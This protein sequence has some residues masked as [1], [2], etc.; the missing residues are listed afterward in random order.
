MPIA[1]PAPPA[2]ADAVAREAACRLLAD[3]RVRSVTIDAPTQTATVYY[4][5]RDSHRLPLAELADSL[6]GDAG[7]L[8]ASGVGSHGGRS[9]PANWVLPTASHQ[10]RRATQ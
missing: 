9:T 5:G 7:R 1:P 2:D 4:R 6:R 3:E 8:A 10:E